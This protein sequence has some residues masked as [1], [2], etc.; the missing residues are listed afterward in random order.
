MG[1]LIIYGSPPSNYVRSVRMACLEKGVPYHFEILPSLKAIAEPEHLARHP[2]AKIP[3]MKHG[4]VELFETSAI[5]RYI[6]EAFDGPPLQPD[7]PAS[8]GRM[9]QWISATNAYVDQDI[10]RRFV[11][12]YIFPSGPDGQ[13]DRSRIDK[14]L[15]LIRRD[16]EALNAALD[17]SDYLAGDALSLADLTLA[18]ILFYGL[19]M[20][21]GPELIS[22]CDNLSA[23]A[24]RML[25]RESFTAT[26]PPPRE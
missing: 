10:M 12:P 25:A 22:G 19:S 9:E 6:D 5:C 13:P 16:M 23:W 4:D 18:P 7:D 11:L 14:A 3:T 26:A 1:D 21:E 17:G 20:P 2:F 8:R 24:D 15:P